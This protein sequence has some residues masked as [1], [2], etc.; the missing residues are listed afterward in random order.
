[1]SFSGHRLLVRK[2]K[3]DEAASSRNTLTFGDA[4]TLDTN[5][6]GGASQSQCLEKSGT[7][8]KQ[9]EFRGPPDGLVP[10]LSDEERAAEQKAMGGTLDFFGTIL[11]MTHN[12]R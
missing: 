9:I 8:C 12:Q 2:P 7:A 4:W 3:A 6:L 11:S 10:A 5:R 1:M